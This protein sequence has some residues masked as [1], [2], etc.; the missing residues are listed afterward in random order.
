V[1]EV[2]AMLRVGVAFVLV[3]AALAKLRH[4]NSFVALVPAYLGVGYQRRA[5]GPVAHKRA[6]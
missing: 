6:G 2:T 3:W 1:A 5:K 4:F